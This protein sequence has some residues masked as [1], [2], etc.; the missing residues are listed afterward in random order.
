MDHLIADVSGID[1]IGCGCAA[2]IIGGGAD[3]ITADEVAAVEGT[4][5]YEV[6]CRMVG[7]RVVKEFVQ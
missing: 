4:V 1:G 5:S 6:L 3:G 2:Y 7:S